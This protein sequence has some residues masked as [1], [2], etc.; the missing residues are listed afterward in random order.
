VAEAVKNLHSR[1][2]ELRNQL[3]VET[4]LAG[5]SIRLPLVVSKKG[6]GS[7]DC[8]PR[9]KWT[10]PPAHGRTLPAQDF[11]PSNF[12]KAVPLP[13]F[14]EHSMQPVKSESS[15]S[16]E[17]ERLRRELLRRIVETEHQRQVARRMAVK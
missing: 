15:R 7:R 13:S 4:C 3:V 16:A 1:W 11:P 17:L 8:E 5:S 10:S 2:A 14:R 9:R 6:Q 12:V